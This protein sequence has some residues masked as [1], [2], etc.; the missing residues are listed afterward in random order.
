M[1]TTRQVVIK[2]EQAIPSSLK[3]VVTLQVID[4]GVEAVVIN[5]TDGEYIRISKAETYSSYLRV[6]KQEEKTPVTK[7]AVTGKYLGMVDVYEL[8]ETELEAEN[9][10][11]EYNQKAGWPVELGLEVKNVV[12]LE[13]QTAIK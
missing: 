6:S 7:F 4:G 5:G 13:Y 3:N 10:L 11:N 9:K 12:V 1:N 2:D 8:F